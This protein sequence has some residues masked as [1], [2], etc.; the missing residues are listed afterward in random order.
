MEIRTAKTVENSVLL[1]GTIT[2]MVGASGHVRDAYNEWLAE[3]NTP[4]S[5]FTDE[6]LVIQTSTSAI[7][8]F[9]STRDAAVLALTVTV[10]GLVYDAN[11]KSQLRLAARL[12]SIDLDEMVKWKLHDNS[13][14]MVTGHQ[15]KA[16]LK[17]AGDETTKIWFD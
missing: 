16:A 8:Q 10:D 14:Q 15:L 9:K 3:G 17:L 2:L 6:E 4:T 5:E 11:E 7:N 13:S 12:A 1:N